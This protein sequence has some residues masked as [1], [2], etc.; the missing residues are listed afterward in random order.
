MKNLLKV[1]FAAVI[2]LYLNACASMAVKSDDAGEKE[3]VVIT[4]DIRRLIDIVGRI[5]KNV[6]DSLSSEIEIIGNIKEKKFKSIGRINFDRKTSRF[7]I[8]FLDY[9]FKSPVTRIFQNGDDIRIYFPADKKLVVDNMNTIDIS[10]YIDLNIHFY[11]IYDL[12]CGHIP[13]L[14]NYK[15]KQGLAS[16]KGKSSY[17]IIENSNYYETISFRGDSPDRL[18][19]IRKDNREKIEIYLKKYISKGKSRYFKNI[20]IVAESSSLRLDFNFRR[21]RINIPVKVK[22]ID[23]IRLP[24]D[25]KLIRL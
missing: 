8:N 10:N 11:L 5:N 22:T 24:K 3:K 9:I 21:T 6:P 12:F 20:R 19:I 23:K 13:L 7:N 16:V 4:E 15:V 25:V 1:L 18:M 14:K 17:L 2:L